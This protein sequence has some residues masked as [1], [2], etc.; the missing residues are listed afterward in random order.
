MSQPSAPTPAGAGRP[1]LERWAPGESGRRTARDWTV[2][3]AAF[4]LALGFGAFAF[5]SRLAQPGGVPDGLATLDLVGGL[6]C[7]A[8]LWWR[9]RFPAALAL[10]TGLFGAYSDMASG[11]GL[12][13]L[14]TVAVHRRWQVVAGVVAVNLVS[15]LVYYRARPDPDLGYVAAAT[16]AASV[17]AAVVAWGMF[18][19]ARRQLIQSLR[20]RAQRAEAEQAQRVEQARETERT[21]IAREMHDVLA[22]RITLL[23]LHAGALEFRP[24]A[25]PDE[26]ARAAGVIRESARQALQELREVIGVL[27][28]GPEDAAGRPQPTLADLP[29]LLEECRRAGT[30][31]RS[32]VRVADPSALPLATGRNAYRIVQEALTNARKHAPGAAVDLVVAGA[33]GEGLRVRVSNPPAV[34]APLGVP[35]GGTGLVGLAERAALAGGRLEHEVGADGRFRLSAHLPWPAPVTAVPS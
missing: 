2:D 9:R 20:E 15:V 24:D 1:V 10:L 32:D 19:R 29:A 5:G 14:F 23:S 27:R 3:V 6:V 34:S 21:R 33:P 28:A 4:V 17:V 22:H 11:A 26:V 12:V 30:R 16:V 8:L 7:C 18:V 35:G 31:I 13:A 25:P